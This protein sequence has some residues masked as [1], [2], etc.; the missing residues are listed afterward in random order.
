[1]LYYSG[2]YWNLEA[3]LHKDVVGDAAWGVLQHVLAVPLLA[4]AEEILAVMA[5]PPRIFAT[6]TY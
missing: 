4:V 2:M 3:V 6:E 1:M 5:D